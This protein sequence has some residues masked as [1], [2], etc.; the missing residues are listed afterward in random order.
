MSDGHSGNTEQLAPAL[1][2]QNGWEDPDHLVLRYM[3]LVRRL[4]RRFS[5]SAELMEDLVQIGTVGLL[6]ATKKYD[7]HRGFSFVSFA[8][9]AIVGEIKNYFRDHGWAV[10]VPRKM[11]SH[12]LVVERI[13]DSLTQ[14]LGCSPTILE[15]AAVTGLSEEQIYDTFQVAQYCKPLSLE[16]E[17]YQEGDQDVSCLLDFVGREDPDIVELPERMD[18]INALPCLNKIEKTVIYLKFYSGL[19]QTKIGE[20]IGTSQMHVSRL[21]RNAIK[22]LRSRLTMVGN[23]EGVVGKAALEP[24]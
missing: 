16:A 1:Q 7:P 5:H 2:N 23:E 17:Y 6:R 8:V 3:P 12:R 11:Q 4:C 21:Q 24:N 9:P 15:I 10:K 22:K 14:S 18:L 19:S 13:I 20:L